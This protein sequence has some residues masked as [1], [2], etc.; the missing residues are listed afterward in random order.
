MFWLFFSEIV[1]V[2][3]IVCI[4]VVIRKKSKCV[5]E[6]AAAYHGSKNIRVNRFSDNYNFLIF[7]YDFSGKHYKQQTLDTVSKRKLKTYK[8]QCVY[9]IHMDR[10]QPERICINNQVTPGEIAVIFFLMFLDHSFFMDKDERITIAVA[11]Y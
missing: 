7:E 4:I 6:I 5:V 9:V 1:F 3:C 8:P 11:T 10:K 2:V